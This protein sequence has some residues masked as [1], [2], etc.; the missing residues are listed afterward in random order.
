MVGLI[1]AQEVV[2]TNDA[3]SQDTRTAETHSQSLM[4]EDK[5]GHA[6]C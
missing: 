3:V 6:Q 4:P 2:E 1:R 5:N